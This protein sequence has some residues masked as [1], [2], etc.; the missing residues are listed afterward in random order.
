M[1]EHYAN[2]IMPNFGSGHVMP[3]H[4]RC[5]CSLQVT[6]QSD[7]KDRADPDRLMS[8][9]GYW[10][11]RETSRS[12]SSQETQGVKS[13][14]RNDFET[15]LDLKVLRKPISFFSVIFDSLKKFR[16]VVHI[17]WGR[18][19]AFPARTLEWKCQTRSWSA[20]SKAQDG[21]KKILFFKG[22]KKTFTI[23]KRTKVGNEIAL[24]VEKVNLFG[25]ESLNSQI[26]VINWGEG[27]SKD[28]G[29]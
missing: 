18:P 14:V 2:G 15:C 28:E 12:A 19:V 4:S 29:I 1:E 16:N 5:Y 9:Q 3:E 21:N 6:S 25:P 11:L 23:K 10:A 13:V 8:L 7:L 20:K 27:V 22:R 17:G 26:W 24:W